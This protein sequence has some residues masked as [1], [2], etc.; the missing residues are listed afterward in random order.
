MKR[1]IAAPLM[2][3]LCAGMVFAQK[4]A[5]S[6]KAAEDE[7][8]Q[9]ENAWTDA[10]KTRNVDK[11]REIL[12]DGWVGLGW[13]GETS[14]KANALADLKSPGNSLDSVEMGT[15]TVRIFGNTAVV[16]GSD[17]EKSMEH[18]KDSSGNYIWTDVFV[19]QSGGW[20]AVASQ[21]AKMP[22]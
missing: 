17:T 10:Q 4:P 2:I 1:L 8:K 18:G 6:S 12:A 9:I 7:L 14:D 15:M 20:R 16:T 3:A 11:L 21:S 19:K 13:D 5:A 22:E